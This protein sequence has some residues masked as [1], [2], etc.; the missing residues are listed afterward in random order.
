MKTYDHDDKS[1]EGMENV[2]AFKEQK[3]ID[4]AHFW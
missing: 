1:N 2:L 3:K 4:Y